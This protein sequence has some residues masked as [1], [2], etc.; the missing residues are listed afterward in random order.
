MRE[1]ARGV[2][3]RIA[4]W[5]AVAVIVCLAA[6]AVYADN[7]EPGGKKRHDGSSIA[8]SGYLQF[9]S[10]FDTTG[11]TAPIVQARRIRYALKGHSRDRFDGKVG[12]DLDRTNFSQ[13]NS[14]LRDC[15]VTGYT[16]DLGLRVG[17][18]DVPLFEEVILS[19]AKREPFERPTVSRQLWPNEMDIGAAFMYRPRANHGLQATVGVFLG[20]GINANGW[21]DRDGQ[22]DILAKVGNFYDSG[23][24]LAYVGYQNGSV[25]GNRPAAIQKQYFV[26]G[27]RWHDDGERWFVY[28]E[29]ATGTLGTPMTGGYAR[30]V[31][32][33]HHGEHGVFVQGQYFDPD[34]TVAGANWGPV[35]GYLWEPSSDFRF[36]VQYD[37]ENQQVGVR[38][39]V[40]F[41]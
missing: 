21:A 14:R 36:T 29:G 10:L 18:M 3:G 7:E 23:N 28:A 4:R 2:I 34:T 20:E 1:S 37:G 41:D 27:T 39:M 32:R 19:S 35:A 15:Y 6:G 11:A 31:Y 9:E 5:G 40:T 22:K 13:F 17:Q 26:A 24:G 38:G 8:G 33:F 12:V 30:G 25:V 16:P